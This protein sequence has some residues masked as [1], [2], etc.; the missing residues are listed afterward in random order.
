MTQGLFTDWAGQRIKYRIRATR[1]DENYEPGEWLTCEI[2][3]H[4]DAWQV[5]GRAKT[6]AN[7]LRLAISAWNKYDQAA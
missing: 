7:C 6:S 5:M 1:A 4:G 3:A 2:N